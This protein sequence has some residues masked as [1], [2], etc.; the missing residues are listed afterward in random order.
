MKKIIFILF[1]VISL[2]ISGCG[3]TENVIKFTVR[4]YDDNG[5][6]INEQLVEEGKS[7][8]EPTAPSKE[9]Y[10][11]IGWDEDFSVINSNIDIFPRYEINKYKVVFKD[12]EGNIISEKEVLHG[13]SA[14]YPRAPYVSGYKFVGWDNDYKNVTEDRV[15]TAQYEVQTYNIKYMVDGK[16]VDL[17]PSTYTILDDASIDL[18]PVIEKEGYECLGWYDGDTRVVT[19]FSGDA[20]DKIFT[21]KYKKLPNPMEIPS[22]AT[23][24]FNNILKKEHSSGNGSYVYQPD[25]SG[26]DVTQKSALDW[27]W[28]SLHEEVA[29]VSMYSSISIASSGYAIIRAQNIQDPSIVG[30]A[31]VKVMPDG[32]TISSIEEATTIVEYDVTFTDESGNIFSTQ[33]VQEGKAAA[34]PTPPTKEGYTFIG[35][36]GDHFNIQENITLEPRYIKGQSNFVGKTV[37]ILGDSI[38]TYNGFIPEGYKYFYPY[39]TADLS[40]VNQTWWMQVINQLGMTLLKNNSYSGS[41]VSTGTGNSGATNDSRLNQLIDM[42]NKP[43][44]IIIYMGANDC[45]SSYVSLNTFDSSYKIMIDKIKVLC[46]ESEI[47]L[48]TLPSTGIYDDDDKIKYNDVIKK[49]ASEYELPLID[50]SST[51]TKDNYAQYCV[52]SC[53]PNKSGMKKISDEII[54]QMLESKGINTNN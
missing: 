39:P 46:P 41:C 19:F 52:D 6:V 16:Y 14:T 38:S 10:T 5:I 26:L 43:D 9:G 13:D 36:S 1:L 11:F 34:L 20:V 47:Y 28:S 7:A 21:L 27:E 4:F 44:I 25:F 2:F 54:K 53:H 30:Y 37:S 45:G 29:T 23:F 40:N 24:M 8:I 32:I 3:S 17:Q 33:K 42:D 22:D 48:L 31:V 35:W 51:F 15:L 50:L 49:Y 18:P 12:I